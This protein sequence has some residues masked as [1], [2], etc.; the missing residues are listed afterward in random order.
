MDFDPRSLDDSR[1]RDIDGR[2]LN[3]GSR[4]GLSNP[5]E[6]E[7]LDPR[8]VAHIEYSNEVWNQGF[9]QA[10]WAVAQ[11]KRLGLPTPYGLGSAFYAERT[12]HVGA[13]FGEVYGAGERRRWRAV[14]AGQAAWT[15]FSADALAWKDTAAKVDALAIASEP[16]RISRTSPS[17]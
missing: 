15:Q 1:D 7:R 8:R 12:Q 16:V 17:R 4:G 13:L 3:Q 10:R 9:E 14:L 5:R 11:S 2:E 6:R